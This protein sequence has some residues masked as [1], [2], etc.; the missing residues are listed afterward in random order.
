MLLLT[1]AMGAQA[2]YNVDY[3]MGEYADQQ[4]L[5][6]NVDIGDEELITVGTLTVNEFT[7]SH[8]DIVLT[9]LNKDGKVIWNIRYGLRD[10]NEIGNGITLSWDKKHVIVVGNVH[11]RTDEISARPVNQALV[12]KIRISDGAVVW[13]THHGIKEYDDQAFLVKRSNTFEDESYVVVGASRGEPEEAFERMYAFKVKDDGNQ[14]WSRRY[15]LGY[16]FPIS[17]IRPSSMVENGFGKFM[18]AGTRSEINRPTR[19]FLL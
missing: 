10:L 12:L 14:V 7:G 16:N 6:S 13:A 3:K 4:T 11:K 19:I 8:Q 2:Q 9:R 5:E 17:S 18:I 1:G 15:Y